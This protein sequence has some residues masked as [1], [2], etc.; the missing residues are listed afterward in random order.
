ML[1]KVPL[2]A[3]RQSE[4]RNPV[5]K[6]GINLCKR[7]YAVILFRQ[8]SGKNGKRQDRNSIAK[9]YGKKVNEAVSD[10]LF[11]AGHTII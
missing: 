3:D 11:F 6:D 5:H 9:D 10:L 4:I 2:V 7:P 1:K 8:N